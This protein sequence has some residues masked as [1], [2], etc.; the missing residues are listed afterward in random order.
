MA[1][2]A[3]T[4]PLSSIPGGTLDQKYMKRGA[5]GGEELVNMD[6]LAARITGNI[7][8]MV[9]KGLRDLAQCAVNARGMLDESVKEIGLSM[10]EFDRLTKG[11]LQHV[12]A[13]R[14]AV[15]SECSQMVNS[16]KDVRQFFL[17]PDYER[18]TERLREFVDL[19]ERL[20][21]LK[22]SGFLDTVADTMIR[23]S[24]RSAW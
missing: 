10:D 1:T 3:H 7:E 5:C 22:D 21:A 11:A 20:K 9:P 24:S 19:C 4:I 17:G 14:M 16:L 2:E 13:T 12:R 6:E 18:E 8:K 15:V 23:L